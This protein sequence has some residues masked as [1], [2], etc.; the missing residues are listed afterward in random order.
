MT[1]IAM[2][3]IRMSQATMVRATPEWA[4]MTKSAGSL[5]LFQ[6]QTRIRNML[7]R[8]SLKEST[9]KATHSCFNPKLTEALLKMIN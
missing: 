7:L 1:T 3:Q 6:K 8:L 2:I 9:A 5:S 4:V